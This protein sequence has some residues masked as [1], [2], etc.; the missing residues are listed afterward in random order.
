MRIL[1]A[2]LLSL[3]MLVIVVPEV[4][5]KWPATCLELN[6]QS[7]AALGNHQ[8]VGIYQR[9]FGTLAEA[10]AACQR[11]HLQ[12]VYSTFWWAFETF[13]ATTQPVPA[14][15]PIPA[16]APAPAP[17][18]P[19]IEAGLVEAWNLLTSLDIPG[20]LEPAGLTHWD[21][22]AVNRVRVSWGDLDGAYGVYSRDSHHII[23][24]R[25]RFQHEP[26]W[27]LATLLA[28]E[29]SHASI[30]N[31]QLSGSYND[32]LWNEV[33][34]FATEYLVGNAL[35]AQVPGTTSIEGYFKDLV[36][37]ALIWKAQARDVIR[38]GQ[39][40]T[41]WDKDLSDLPIFVI[42]LESE[43]RYAEHCAR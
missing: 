27:I 12:D 11:D 34:A 6:D 23:I 13:Q 17:A 24:D 21:W 8:N 26:P 22:D 19:Q 42:Y 3:A 40:I 35:A 7:E 2:A 43:R 41:W 37:M 31:W 5:G 20:I 30:P 36:T 1:R 39:P 9:A 25:G 15:S 10:E 29:L 14:P 28:H 33:L 4:A 32:C 18:R 38:R 16:P